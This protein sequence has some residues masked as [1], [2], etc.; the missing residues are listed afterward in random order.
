MVFEGLRLI[1]QHELGPHQYEFQM[2]LGVDHQLRDILIRGGHKVRIYV[3]FG[4][5]WYAYSMRR[6]KENPAIAG[7]ILRNL[8]RK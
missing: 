8:F 3:P 5:S 4:G 6:L 1:Y 2:L 7:Y